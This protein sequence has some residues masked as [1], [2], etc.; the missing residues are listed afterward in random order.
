MKFSINSRHIGMALIVLY[1]IIMTSNSYS[2]GLL[3][4]KVND[5]DNGEFYSGDCKNGL[6]DGVGVARGRDEYEGS[7]KAGV[8]HGRGKYIWGENSDWPGDIYEGDWLN[9]QRTGQG[10]YTW[11]NGIVFEGTFKKGFKM[12]FGSE[13]IP[14]AEFRKREMND[15]DGGIWKGN[16]YERT[17]LFWSNKFIGK[18]DSKS[19]CFDVL[20]AYKTNEEDEMRKELN[21]VSSEMQTL[22]D[23]TSQAIDQKIMQ[24]EQEEER[25]SNSK[26]EEERRQREL[27]AK[28]HKQICLAQRETC[29]A[30]C[31]GGN[32]V[33]ARRCRSICSDRIKCN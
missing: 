14:L 12:G 4:C 17:G 18:C 23:Q 21:Q 33:E 24:K 25:L 27:E 1:L 31:P 7:F 9:G 29:R 13:K 15:E 3:D 11:A 2:A 26:R 10:K 30:S 8:Q 16:Y 32:H 22:I 5:P 28:R 19:A 20:L 6:A